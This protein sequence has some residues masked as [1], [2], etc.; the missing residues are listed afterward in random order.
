MQNIEFSG[1]NIKILLIKWNIFKISAIFKMFWVN[2][3]GFETMVSN[4]QSV[5]EKI[6]P[7]DQLKVCK[8]ANFEA[9]FNH[10][11]DDELWFFWFDTKIVP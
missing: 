9:E 1:S 11:R 4:M 7:Y 3:I 10:E 8:I 6:H 2:I 5:F